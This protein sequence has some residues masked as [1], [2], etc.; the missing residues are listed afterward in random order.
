MKQ[1]GGFQDSETFTPIPDTLFRELLKIIVDAAELKVV[2]HAIWSL[3]RMDGQLRALTTQDFAAEALGISAN[4]V[5]SGLQKAIEH[6][7]VLRAGRGKGTRY[8]LNSPRGRAT[9]RA[10]ANGSLSIS[11]GS[12]SAP[13]ERTN[14]FAV[15]EQN[16]GPLTPLIADALKDAEVSYKPEWIIEAIDLAVQNNKRSWSYCQA[17]LRRW[18]EEGRGKKPNRRD[19]QAD[20]Q[21]DV[22]EKIRRFIRG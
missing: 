8:L 17:I 7:I 11:S 10:L 19:N 14:V 20:R 5:K 15:Y 13:L 3:E 2:L 18:K 21:R 16:I 9:A 1:F 22:E 12:S 4:E 6:Q